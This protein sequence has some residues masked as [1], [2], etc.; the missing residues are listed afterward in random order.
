MYEIDHKNAAA[1]QRAPAPTPSYNHVQGIAAASFL[2]WGEHCVECAEPSC[3][4]TCDLYSSRPDGKCRRFTDGIVRN[5]A[6]PSARGYGA[7]ISF[8][9]WGK[10]ESRGN[11]SLTPY[12]RLLAMEGLVNGSKPVIDVLGAVISR[13][14]GDP[15]WRSVRSRMLDR[16][17]RRWHARRRRGLR[18][19]VFLL[20]VFNPN[21]RPAVL[22]V[23]LGIARKQLAQR[24]LSPT[25]ILPLFRER[26]ELA[27]GYS[28]HEIPYE[29][30][31]SVTE[32]GLPFDIALIPEADSNPTLIFLCADFV[33]YA[34]KASVPAIVN[35]KLAVKCVVWDLDNTMWKG[36]LLE[37]DNVQ[38][39]AKIL[40]LVKIL[41]S[42]G[43]LMSV[44]S[45][46]DFMLAHAKLQ[47]FGM[48]EYILYPQINWQSKSENIKTIAEKLN[49]GLDTVAFIDDNDFELNEVA[50]SLPMVTC[51]NARDITSL[52]KD[53]RFQ[54]STTAEA[55]RRR[56]MY[57]QAMERDDDQ[58]KFGDNFFEF[59]KSCNIKLRL[60][61]YSSEYFERVCELLQRTNQLNFSGRKYRREEIGSIISDRSLEKWVLEC[62]D[63]YG[64]Y[65][66][67]GFSLV[68]CWGEEIRI[69]D[70]MLSCRVQ[71]RFV[72]QAFFAALIEDHPAVRK[73]TVNFT[74]TGRNAPAQQ[75]LVAM[76]FDK[77]P[78]R[79][80]M[81][82]DLQKHSLACDFIQ[83][84]REPALE[85]AE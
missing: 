35:D 26:V 5:E 82:M 25:T 43:I 47:E 79:K 1:P 56:L 6:F 4:Q 22:Q 7:E 71:A 64:S 61:P 32:A 48:E 65:G 31:S 16:A 17:I 27:P 10:L 15:R 68:A 49:I 38:I 81:I 3:F 46:N 72:E 34:A 33:R 52:A 59:L 83:V 19:D 84:V 21:D 37:D 70:F 85:G 78:E 55:K 75:V 36:V 40:D 44:A 42:R 63:K 58:H 29:K 60:L 67:V 2:S 80:G 18:P 66:V 30:M 57:R 20:E 39:D 69:E 8:K 50:R 51:I 23:S 11:V 74:A 12:K 45:K 73:L 77:D 28:C 76:G 62:S 24:G 9:K 54:G 41:D 13:I 14:T 53:P